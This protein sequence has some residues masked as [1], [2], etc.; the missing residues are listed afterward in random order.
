MPGLRSRPDGA[1]KATCGILRLAGLRPLRITGGID[2]LPP[3]VRLVR[4]NCPRLRELSAEDEI[5]ACLATQ[6]ISFGETNTLTWR[7][8]Y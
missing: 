7:E 1:T 2:L 3:G 8:I 5:L 6:T 4:E